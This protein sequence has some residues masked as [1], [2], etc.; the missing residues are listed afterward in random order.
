MSTELFAHET[1]SLL[2]VGQLVQYKV[3]IA[4]L[5]NSHEL[6]ALRSELRPE[7]ST[8]SLTPATLILAFQP[9]SHASTVPIA[10][11]TT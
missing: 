2:R 9:I 10:R 6:T 5:R 1:R 4:T 3:A 11:L 7:S 8:I